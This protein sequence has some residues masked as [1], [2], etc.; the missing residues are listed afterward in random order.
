MSEQT[1][2]PDLLAACEA[3]ITAARDAHQHW[4]AD[5]DMKVGK[6]L[7]AMS[8]YLKGYRAELDAA[9]AAIA[10]AKAAAQPAAPAAPAAAPPCEYCGGAKVPGESC[11]GNDQCNYGPD[12]GPA[13]ACEG[14]GRYCCK[15]GASYAIGQM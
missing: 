6:L 1:T 4:D 12:G 13:L 2:G 15:C 8:G 3:L 14:W 5:R 10:R 7:C 9:H 11:P